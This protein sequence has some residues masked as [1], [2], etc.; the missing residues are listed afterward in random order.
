[1]LQDVT[2]WLSA[3]LLPSW[4]VF[5]PKRLLLSPFCV[6]CIY[7]CLALP[8]HTSL[9]SI[10][11]ACF[12]DSI[13]SR[14]SSKMLSFSSIFYILREPQERIV[15]KEGISSFHIP[16]GKSTLKYWSFSKSVWWWCFFLCFFLLVILSI[17]DTSHVSSTKTNEVISGYSLRLLS[18]AV[19]RFWYH[20]KFTLDTEVPPFLWCTACLL[21]LP[22][23][24]NWT[25]HTGHSAAPSSVAGLQ[26]LTIVS[27]CGLFFP[28]ATSEPSNKR[29][30]LYM[31][32]K[33]SIASS[34]AS[35]PA[36]KNA[37]L[38]WTARRLLNN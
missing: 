37:L 10:N 8:S 18:T 24:T 7:S 4:V 13:M 33:Q 36:R 20:T 3:D 23:L 2:V 9:L 19:S 26:S 35:W 11:V 12:S 31:W 34:I 32:F 21:L 1:M 15:C 28:Q 16:Y 38:V 30:K 29:T 6:V 27:T 5:S 22:M 17:S 14:Y 25:V